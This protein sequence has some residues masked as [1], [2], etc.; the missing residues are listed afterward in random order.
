MLPVT[1]DAVVAVVALPFSVPFKF[2]PLALFVKTMPGNCASVIVPFNWLAGTEPSK[3][4]AVLAKT[5]Y[6]TGRIDCRGASV[7]KFVPP[8]VRTLIC[9]HTFPPLNTP[10]PKSNVRENK[11]FVTPVFKLVSVPPTCPT[12][13]LELN[14]A[15]VMS[16]PPFAGALLL[17][18][19]P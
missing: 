6:G 11:P 13:L 18:S 14:M 10:E 4:L 17:L 12:P 9:S 8:L 2:T 19:L 1:F 15:N 5:A 3:L 16:K 7:V